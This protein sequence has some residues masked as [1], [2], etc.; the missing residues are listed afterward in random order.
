VVADYEAE[1]TTVYDVHHELRDGVWT[2]VQADAVS[3]SIPAASPL[4]Q[5]KAE[6]ADFLDN[7]RTRRQPAANSVASGVN[8]AAI[9]DAFDRSAK[10]RERLPIV[11]PPVS[12]ES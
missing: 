1:R 5:I 3:P 7:V 4:D 12:R 11:M 2:A 10:A 9:I 8:L 6:L